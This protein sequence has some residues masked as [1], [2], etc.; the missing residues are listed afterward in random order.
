MLPRFTL[1]LVLIIPNYLVAEELKCEAKEPE[2]SWKNSLREIVV[3]TVSKEVGIR[4]SKDR[5]LQVVPLLYSKNSRFS[6]NKPT[7]SKNQFN[8][9]K[10]FPSGDDWRIISVG[11]T[12]LNGVAILRAGGDGEDFECITK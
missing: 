10:L 5:K 8:A 9:Y 4:Y 3:N 6:F 7:R 1:L 2:Y 12:D 11:L